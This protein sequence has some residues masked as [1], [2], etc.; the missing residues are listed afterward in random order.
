[1]PKYYYFSFLE[2]LKMKTKGYVI[3]ERRVNEVL[4]QYRELKA[5]KDAVGK[6]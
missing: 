3:A 4:L 5:R 1:M 6:N 2:V